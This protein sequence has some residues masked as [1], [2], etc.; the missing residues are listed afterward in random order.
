MANKDDEQIKLISAGLSS[1][2]ARKAAKKG[3]TIEKLNTLS[4]KELTQLFGYVEEG[5]VEGSSI[6]EAVKRKPISPET[7]KKLVSESDWKCCMCWDISEETPVIIHHI[8]L[9]SKTNDD[10]YENLVVLCPNHHALAHSSWKISRHPLPPELLKERKKNWTQAIAEFKK[11]LR[12]APTKNSPNKDVFSQSDRD[13]LNRLRMFLDRPAI[14]QPFDLEGNM[15][16]FLKAITDVIQALNTGI[17]ETRKGVEICRTKPRSM[18]S[19][20]KW[21]EKLDL[22]TSRFEDLR[23]RFEIAVRN[24]ELIFR[25]DGF[26]AFHNR[27]LPNEIDSMRASIVLMFNE[28]LQEAELPPLKGINSQG[29]FRR[30]WRG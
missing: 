16:D 24:N 28:L 5:A 10:S 27:E 9:H 14:H 4:Q 15:A 20:P 6:S 18:L 29:M 8:N 26:Y 30:F 21:M 17:L 11:G 23:T 12:P 22:I 13:T 19:N 25:P 1:E 3:Y 2:I 7:V